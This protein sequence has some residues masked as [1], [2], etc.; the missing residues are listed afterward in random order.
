MRSR[1]STSG[2]PSSR[3]SCRCS[4]RCGTARAAS[5]AERPP[6]MDRPLRFALV[7][8]EKSGDTLGAGLIAALRARFPDAEFYGVAGEQ[9]VA[10]GCTAWYRAEEL[11]VMGLAEVL[12]HLPRL[13]KL[14][15]DLIR[16]L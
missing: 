8:G 5:R 15:R 14:R 9:M 2:R 11:S 12:S 7:A 6:A 16:R 10:A 3:S 13:L 4:R 1:R